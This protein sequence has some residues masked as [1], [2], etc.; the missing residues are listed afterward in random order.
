MSNPKCGPQDSD[1]QN[2][3]SCPTSAKPNCSAIKNGNCTNG[4]WG[5]GANIYNYKAP[6]TETC[7]SLYNRTTGNYYDKKCTTSNNPCCSASANGV[8]GTSCNPANN[9]YKY[10]PNCAVSG[11][12]VC[13]APT[14][15]SCTGSQTSVPGTRTASYVPSTTSNTCNTPI[16]YETQS[17][18]AQCS[19]CGR[20]NSYTNC[21]VDNDCCSKNGICG[22]GSG[23]CN[24]D[25]NNYLNST[26]GFYCG[27]RN[28][29]K[30][31]YNGDMGYKNHQEYCVPN[32]Y[33]GRQ[34]K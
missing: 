2:W 19:K 31:N 32:S 30:N 23:F 13:I 29:Y 22:K 11:W 10:L 25:D 7:G 28:S 6:T 34:D 5:P 24:Y 20:Q 18:D 27:P 21:T 16:Q 9:T 14:G 8:C 12:G 33:P 17:C 1:G 26:Q 15:V 4:A 3:G